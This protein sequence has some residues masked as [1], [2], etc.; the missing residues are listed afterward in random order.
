VAERYED[1]YGDTGTPYQPNPYAPPTQPA[2]EGHEWLWDEAQ[3]SWI[4]QPIA[5]PAA[6]APPPTAPP[7]TNAPA[8]EPNPYREPDANPYVPAAAAPAAPPAPNTVDAFQAWAT[9]RYGRAATPAEL[10]QIRTGAGISGGVN[11]VWSPEEFGKAQTY[12]D[13][14]ASQQGWPGAAAPGSPSAPGG[15]SYFP[16][17]TPPT[18]E[19]F[20]EFQ[21]PAPFS[22]DAF[23][24]QPFKAP[25]LEDAQ[26]EP[27]YA[28][29][30]DEGLKGVEASAAARGMLRTGG[31]LK[32]L[33][34][35][36]NKFAEQ[37]YGNV[38]N[39][40]ADTYDRNAG[41]A[42]DVWGA[43]RDN[44]AANYATNY[45]ISRDTWDRGA[46]QHLLK[47]DRD[48]KGSYDKFAFGREAQKL[49]LED[50]YK[51]RDYYTDLALMNV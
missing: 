11:G 14:L 44:A 41:M 20:P 30:R 15:E 5:A 24:Y 19:K 36:G 29:A 10:D 16:E 39:R 9:P 42:F 23:S 40:A 38:Y 47:A 28:F 31:S 3:G 48:Y 4:A 37:N 46:E 50:L 27:G 32:D 51:N 43:N 6:A 25:T 35:W 7:A 17:F 18:Y 1:Y 21:A 33:F 12:A 22:Y 34:S 26:K 49:T 8:V 13:T 2:P 45:G